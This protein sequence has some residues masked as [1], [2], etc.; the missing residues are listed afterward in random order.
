MAIANA[1]LRPIAR[2]LYRVRS[3]VTCMHASAA[4]TAANI[5]LTTYIVAHF[6]TV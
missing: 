3:C 1:E 6:N 4:I 5:H 2:L